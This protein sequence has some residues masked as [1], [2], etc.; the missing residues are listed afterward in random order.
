MSKKIIYVNFV[1]SRL[2]NII[3][4]LKK[5]L[6][7][8]FLS[9]FTYIG[10]FVVGVFSFLSKDFNWGIYVPF[11]MPIFIQAFT[12]VVTEYE[13]NNQ[14]EYQVSPTNIQKI[15]SIISGN[16][17]L[18]ILNKSLATNTPK[19]LIQIRINSATEVVRLTHTKNLKAEEALIYS[20]Y[21]EVL[22]EFSDGE[23]YC[24]AKDTFLCIIDGTYEQMKKRIEI[25]VNSHA[26]F[27]IKIDKHSYY[28]CLITGIT[29]LNTC[30]A[31]SMSI[32]EYAC[33]K[34]FHS[35]KVSHYF[36]FG[37]EFEITNHIDMRKG[38]RHVRRALDECELGLFAQPIVPIDGIDC[39]PKYELL[40]RQYFNGE[41]NSPVH[42]L[43]RAKYNGV[44]QDVDMYVV[45]L[46]ASNFHQLFG[47]R[48]EN[49][50]TVSVNISGSS[51]TSPHFN[52]ALVRLFKLHG[53]PT[54]KIVLE[55]TENIV[56]ENEDD[57]I[58]NM[59][60]FKDQGFKLALD[61][62]GIGSSNFINMSRFPVDYY[63]ID[64]S[65][66]ELMQTDVG[67]RNFVELIVSEAHRR[68]KQVI[69]EGVPNEE[70]L[71]YLTNLGVHFSQSFITGKPEEI[72][73]AP[74]NSVKSR[75]YEQHKELL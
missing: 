62:I 40:L 56:T 63:K 22:T 46:L 41:I 18:S 67:I 74:N 15:T 9:P 45:E 38:L 68:N 12:R 42:I 69:A 54:H 5:G 33:E 10:A 65:Y 26:P 53:I 55:V 25:F 6:K 51:Y 57:A 35:A 60:Y 32:L 58:V 43:S 66:C 20:I 8:S 71:N 13:N 14:S 37:D 11:M 21:L 34:A 75:S 3:S 31:S 73:A 49:I 19:L 7:E 59:H 52:Q 72:I 2:K 64:R 61:D 29:P 27:E 1:R 28:P 4:S 44:T 50:D 17:L 30:V 39:K 36:L 70:A 24:L 16:A 47:L 48:G 23:I